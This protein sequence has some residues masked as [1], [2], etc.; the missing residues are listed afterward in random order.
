M[1]GGMVRAVDGAESLGFAGTSQSER[2]A[3]SPRSILLIDGGSVFTKLALVGI[4]D[5]QYRLLA[6]TQV[7]TTVT[8]PFSDLLI[9]VREGCQQL[10]ALTGRRLVGPESI[11]TPEQDDGS[12]VDTIALTTS[13]GGPLRLLTTGPGREALAGLLYKSLS[14]LFAQPEALPLAPVEA[15]QDDPVWGDL[16]AQLRALRPHAIVVIGAPSTG[17]RGA[18]SITDHAQ[19]VARW[20]DVLRS[21]PR[22]SEETRLSALPVVFSGTTEDGM[23]LASTLRSATAMVHTVEQLTPTTIGPL[24]R[25]LNALYDGVVLR[26]A[27]G[28]TRLRSLAGPATA[29]ITSL[30]GVARFLAH[31]YKMNVAAVDVGASSTTLAG[32]TTSGDFLPALFP[33]GG[34]G[35]GAGYILRAVGASSILRW[36][37]IEA[38]E[39][40]VR[41]HVLTRILRRRMIPTTQL[42]LELEYALAREAIRLAL[43]APGSRLS[44]LHPVDVL[45][46]TGGTLTNTPHPAH[47]ALILLDAM[48]PRGI[49]S[50][51]LDAGR[52]ATMLGS[53]AAVA[54]DVAAQMT[55]NDAMPSLLGTAV[56]VIGRPVDDQP[57]V[58]AF[59]E[60]ED[61]KKDSIEVAAGTLARLAVPHGR[62]ALLS[63]YPAPGVD[64][65]LG[66]GQ[67]ARASEP[68]EG[69]ALGLI[70]DAR[71]RPLELPTTALERM[72][73]LREWRTAIGIGGAR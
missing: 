73:R 53:V 47:T 16:V 33:Q 48:Q 13:V 72:A 49:T 57:A 17:I 4:V 60:Y 69:G 50:L 46:A 25:A 27:P 55:E 23:T 63:L 52:I 65:G 39:N 54:P 71:G 24:S 45:L 30:A 64:V 36:L 56:S 15:T 38:D 8:P 28:Y 9:G 42:E 3:A 12:G 10:E 61:G 20:L 2:R 26:E 58:R 67:Q 5:N 70:I 59:L 11:L 34:V 62:R 43:H 6:R 14:G 22:E 51:V 29:T 19:S 37:V 68:V 32:A 21:S 40:T 66:P 41:E 35:P 18:G 31:H 7:P 44:G 1:G